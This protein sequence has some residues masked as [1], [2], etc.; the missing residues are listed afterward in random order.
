[1]RQLHFTKLKKFCQVIGMALINP[2]MCQ[3]FGKTG[4]ELSRER[5][6]ETKNYI[7]MLDL[8]G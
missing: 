4:K 7:L 5:I 8:M 6:I 2:W 1:M 3:V